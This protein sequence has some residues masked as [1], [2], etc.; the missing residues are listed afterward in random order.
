MP[1]VQMRDGTIVDIPDDASPEILQRLAKANASMEPPKKEEK[2]LLGRAA[3]YWGEVLPDKAKLVGSS[4]VKGVLGLP[5]LAADLLTPSTSPDMRKMQAEALAN[6]NSSEI[7]G[8][9]LTSAETKKMLELKM[10]S[11]GQ[12]APLNDVQFGKTLQDSMYKP[13]TVGEKYIDQA[14]QGAAGAVT[15]PGSVAR[16]AVIGALAGTGGEAAGQVTIKD[17]NDPNDQGNPIARVIAS[18]LTGGS[19]SALSSF[20]GTKADLAKKLM[21]NLSKEDL[22]SGAATML[23]GKAE[24]LPL[25][26]NQALPEN[27]DLEAMAKYLASHETGQ[28]V[29]KTLQNQPANIA[30]GTRERVQNLPGEA[31]SGLVEA[32]DLKKQVTDAYNALRKERSDLVNPLYNS[33]GD[34]GPVANK[35]LKDEVTAMLKDPNMDTTTAQKLKEL[36]AELGKSSVNGKPR[37]TALAIR[38]AID[39]ALSGVNLEGVAPLSPRTVGEIKKAKGTLYEA[40]SDTAEQL[41]KPQLSQANAAYKQ[42]TEEKITPFKES[43]SG[44]ILGPQGAIEGKN[45]AEAP[46]KSLFAGEDPYATGSNIKTLAKDLENTA[47][48]AVPDA[49][50]SHLSSAVA[51]IKDSGNPATQLMDKLWGSEAAKTATMRGLGVME[52]SAEVPTGTYS[53]GF[54]RWMG[55][56]ENVAKA[57]VK[58]GGLSAAEIAQTGSSNAISKGLGV[59]TIAPFAGPKDTVSKLYLKSALLDIDKLFT[60]P[61]GLQLLKELSKKSTSDKVAQGLITTFLQSGREARRLQQAG[62]AEQ[63]EK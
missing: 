24:G 50:K 39:D 12:E 58:A 17:R 26:L 15:S 53:K 38:N 47:P 32:N 10:G 25:T 18:V 63:E 48:M 20:A 43:I 35:A 23:K 8:M 44:K 29:K 22:E 41:G 14:I 19:A 11:K 37:T 16:N 61:E 21:Q 60:N 59:F 40:L 62:E 51:G 42:F 45:A 3:E 9:G 6:R 46:V 7:P 34:L 36:R 52:K 54:K 27:T 4:A 1:Q 33:A 31:K 55:L 49:F 13:K 30:G 56:I 2:G 5:A 57:D 28:T